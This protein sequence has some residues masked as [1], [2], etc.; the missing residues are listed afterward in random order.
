MKKINIILIAFAFSCICGKSYSQRNPVAYEVATWQGFREAAVSYTFDDNC[1]NQLAM[2]I[3]LFNEFGFR[4]TMFIPSAW[5]KDWTGLQSAADQ[6][7]EIA[8]HTVTHTNL[9]SLTTAQQ[10]PEFKDSQASINAHIQGHSCLTI[11]YPYCVPGNDSLCAN[12]YIAARHCQGNVELKTPP[13][14][15]KI[16]SMGTGSASSIQTVSDFNNKVQKADSLNGWCVFLIHGIDKDGGYSP[17]SSAILRSHLDYMKLHSARFWIAPFGN[18]VRYIKERNAVTVQEISNQKASISIQVSD[19]LENSVYNY[20]LTIRR[21]LPKSW[22]SATMSQNGKDLKSEI[23]RKGTSKY[24]V[25]DVVPD[26]GDV[27]ILKARK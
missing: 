17:T 7:H 23:I 27:L 26:R 10:L 13:D 15:M 14:F 2:A 25:F 4:T 12:Y 24:I 18:V 9:G 20:P 8:S 19:T 5:M 6:G 1:P 22:K 11:A 21:E 16:S 3:P